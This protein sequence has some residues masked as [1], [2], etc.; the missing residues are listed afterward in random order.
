VP[1]LEKAQTIEEAAGILKKTLVDLDNAL[2]AAKGLIDDLRKTN[3]QL[4]TTLDEANQTLAT[5]QGT[6]KAA[7]RFVN[8]GTGFLIG[9]PIGGL[10]CALF[11]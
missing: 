2:E 8:T 3:Q 4:Q 6:G 1:E 7:T 9:G 5:W 11:C 10:A